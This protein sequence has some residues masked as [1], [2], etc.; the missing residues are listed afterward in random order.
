MTAFCQKT[1][2]LLGVNNKEIDVNIPEGRLPDK[3]YHK[4]DRLSSFPNWTWLCKAEKERPLLAF[5]GM[6]LKTK[7]FLQLQL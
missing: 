5:A 3:V 1:K 6:T 4:V 7:T 2:E